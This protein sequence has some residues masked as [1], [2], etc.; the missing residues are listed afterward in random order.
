MGA[1]EHIHSRQNFRFKGN[2]TLEVD[3]FTSK[4]GLE[5]L[6]YHQV[7]LQEFMKLLN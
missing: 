6:Q 7:H 4:G 5:E 3:V 1:I 2:P